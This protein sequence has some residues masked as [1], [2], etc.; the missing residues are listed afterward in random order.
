VCVRVCGGL[1][2]PVGWVGK[3]GGGEGWVP[4]LAKARGGM[5]W[6][7]LHLTVTPRGYQD[8][9]QR[10]LNLSSSRFGSRS[11]IYRYHMP[12][13]SPGGKSWAPDLRRPHLPSRLLFRLCEFCVCVCLEEGGGKEG[14]CRVVR[15]IA[16][17]YWS[18]K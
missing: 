2:E 18:A 1:A 14:G 3:S 10:V 15:G 17:H 13:K 8:Q 12:R 7:A 9:G 5:G 11:S 4:G 6:E 16:T